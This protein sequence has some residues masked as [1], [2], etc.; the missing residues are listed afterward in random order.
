MFSEMW[1]SIF[2]MCWSTHEIRVCKKTEM[3]DKKKKKK[4]RK[5]K[6]KKTKKKK[7]KKTTLAREKTNSGFRRQSE[8][9][10]RQILPSKVRIYCLSV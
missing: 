6:K 10:E 4:K 8:V 9:G 7:K 5:K 2:K 1:G 3:C